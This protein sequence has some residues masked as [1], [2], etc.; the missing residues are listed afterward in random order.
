MQGHSCMLMARYDS[1][2]NL[3][4]AL[5]KFPS[6]TVLCATEMKITDSVPRVHYTYQLT[7]SKYKGMRRQGSEI[8]MHNHAKNK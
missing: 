6:R 5:R 1:I 2:G 3:K 4:E 8:T 7:F